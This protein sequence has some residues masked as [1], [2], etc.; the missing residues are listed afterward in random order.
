MIYEIQRDFLAGDQDGNIDRAIAEIDALAEEL[1]GHTQ[2]GRG[3]GPFGF[4]GLESS[5]QPD[6]IDDGLF[7]APATDARS[8]TGE[9]DQSTPELV[10]GGVAQLDEGPAVD[11]EEVAMPWM[12]GVDDLTLPWLDEIDD[13]THQVL[14]DQFLHQGP[15]VSTQSMPSFFDHRHYEL[16]DMNQAP[17]PMHDFI[18]PSYGRQI[19]PAAQ[20]GLEGMGIHE[21][22]HW[23]GHSSIGRIPRSLSNMENIS[24]IPSEARF[25]LEYYSTDVVDFMCHLP[26]PQSPWRTIHFPGAMSTMADL[27]VFGSTNNAR[28]ALFYALLSISANHLGSKIPWSAQLERRSQDAARESGSNDSR[29]MSNYWLT[30][31]ASFEDMATAKIQSCLDLSDD[32]EVYRELLVSLLSMVTISVTSGKLDR[33]HVYLQ[34]A[35]K[36]IEMFVTRSHGSSFKSSKI[37]ALHQI[38]SYLQIIYSSTHV[39]KTLNRSG[40]EHHDHVQHLNDGETS[41]EVLPATIVG[42]LSI[43]TLENNLDSLAQHRDDYQLFAKIYGVPR[44]LLTL[45]SRASALAQEVEDE[46]GTPNSSSPSTY[47]FRTRCE[48]LEDQICNW[49]PMD[50]EVSPMPPSTTYDPEVGSH[51]VQAMHDALIVMFFRRVRPVNRMVLQHYVESAADHL[52][53]QEDVKSRTGVKQPALLWPWFMVAS[54]AIREP[55]RDKLRLWSSLARQYGG[56]NLEVAEHV[57]TEVWRR[58]DLHLPGS[59]WWDVVRDWDVTLVL[60]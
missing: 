12:M 10:R 13:N 19:P 8:S 32:H 26:N 21:Q 48:V 43:P 41:V 53:E 51:L 37:A 2:F 35:N 18:S 52:N 20:R 46:E 55:I 36:L 49:L 28:M 7:S 29:A 24:R 25:L 17:A 22:P 60:T 11:L 30:K 39:S 27:L 42:P 58:Q 33:A 40:L 47:S 14:T 38:Y 56:R 16:A 31:G 15:G 45:I 57:V 34:R 4:F 50:D 6:M 44:S 3:F 5:A 23:T 9:E 59:A 54:E 1:K